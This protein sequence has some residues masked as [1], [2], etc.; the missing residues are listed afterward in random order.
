[1]DEKETDSPG[2]NESTVLIDFMAKAVGNDRM[3]IMIKEST[4]AY[5]NL[6]VRPI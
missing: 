2:A 6:I 3:A 5:L 4:N 1:V